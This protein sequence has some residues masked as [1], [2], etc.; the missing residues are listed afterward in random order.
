MRILLITILLSA[1]GACRFEQPIPATLE[2]DTKNLIGDWKAKDGRGRVI[3]S[4][5]R[6]GR[7]RMLVKEGEQGMILDGHVIKLDGQRFLQTHVIAMIDSNKEQLPLPNARW[8]IWKLDVKD[9][10]MTVQVAREIPFTGVTDNAIVA[11]STQALADSKN[12]GPARTW[13]WVGSDKPAKL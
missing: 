6:Y 10:V 7:V 8:M 9:K 3:I 2:L 12:F 5:L 13:K 1:L 4:D 11:S